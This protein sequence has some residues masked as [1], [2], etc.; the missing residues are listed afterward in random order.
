M[1][2][3][4][5]FL[6]GSVHERTPSKSA[7]PLRQINSSVHGFPA[8]QHRS[9]S[10]FARSRQAQ[11]TELQSQ[12]PPIVESI[13]K[14]LA[15]D[16]Q[17]QQSSS[18]DWRAQ[19]SADNAMRVASMTDEERE[20]AKRE[21]IERFGIGVGDVLKRARQARE[22]T[23]TKGRLSHKHRSP[24]PSSEAD[25]EAFQKMTEGAV[26]RENFIIIASSRCWV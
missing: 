14:I 3:S 7:T 25:K 21:V 20:A 9:Q 11:R 17:S 10:A 6:L 16:A 22:M 15:E 19:V 18:N 23:T 4:G 1:S 12:A 2:Q 26:L 24:P 13:P 5:Q 8:V